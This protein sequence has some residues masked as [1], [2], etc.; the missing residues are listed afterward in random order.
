MWLMLAAAAAL[1]AP[2]LDDMYIATT[3]LS[4][5]VDDDICIKSACVV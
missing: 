3:Q 4:Q 2:R 1:P 5:Q